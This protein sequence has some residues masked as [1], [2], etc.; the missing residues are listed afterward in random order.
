LL[1]GLSGS[2][3]V[4]SMTESKPQQKRLFG[5]WGITLAWL[6]W[7]VINSSRLHLTLDHRI[8]WGTAFWYGMPDAL[9]W[10]GLTPVVVW[11]SRRYE[12]DGRSPLQA[13]IL[14]GGAALSI[15]L[16]HVGVDASLSALHNLAVGAPA[17]FNLIF[18]KLLVHNTH[19]NVLIYFLVSG[20][21]HYLEYSRRLAQRERLNVEL[22]TELTEAQLRSLQM[23]LRP[24]FLFNALHTVSALMHRDPKLGQRVVRQLGDLLR[25]SLKTRDQHLIPLEEELD[26]VRTY[27]EVESAR[28]ED[29]LRV[30]FQVE[31][32]ALPY[33]VPALILQPVVENAVHHGVSKT[34]TA[35]SFES[36]PRAKARSSGSPCLMTDPASDT[37]RPRPMNTGWV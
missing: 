22:K 6:L 10:A 4:G 7:G 8:D 27:L 37:R 12:I 11:L 25:T 1:K 29:R 36:R 35:A 17:N 21:T 18:G 28:F 2:E 14:H 20:F 19:V 23:Q 16:V 24:H 30:E 31:E 26:L 5:W 34:R 13:L 3:I 15:A 33:P 32:A 9:I